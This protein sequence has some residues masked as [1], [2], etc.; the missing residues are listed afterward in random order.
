MAVESNSEG[1]MGPLE[2]LVAEGIGEHDEEENA[3]VVDDEVLLR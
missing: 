2:V 1:S 3:D